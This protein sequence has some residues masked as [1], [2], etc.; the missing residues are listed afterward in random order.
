[1][2]RDRGSTTAELAVGLPAL[3][4]LLLFGLGAVNAVLARMQCVDAARDAA[5]ASARGGDGASE[6]QR[7]APR[8]ASVSVTL[9]GERATATVRVTVHPLGR[10]LPSVTVDG[11]AVADREPQ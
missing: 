9:D 4:L 1:V 7:R 6:G 10:Y 3:M 5:L 8:G 2:S 11:T